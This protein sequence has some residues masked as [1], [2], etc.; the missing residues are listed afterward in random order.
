M[1]I[2]M[3]DPFE[4]IETV[5]VFGGGGNYVG[6]GMHAFEI[7][8]CILKDTRE[9]GLAFIAE[10]KVIEST[11]ETHAPG[12]RRTFFQGFKYRETALGQIKAFVMAAYG[13]DPRDPQALALCEG[14]IR[15][16]T[17]RATSEENIL[18]GRKVACEGYDSLTK[19][20]KRP[21]VKLIWTAIEEPGQL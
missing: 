4:G 11:N 16:L 18:C 19:K 1:S 21:I 9:Q 14:K 7:E 2:T 6:P 5:E 12:T 10:L 15:E 3:R 13:Y 20:E 8:R 17:T